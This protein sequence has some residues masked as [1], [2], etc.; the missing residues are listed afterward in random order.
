MTTDDEDPEC[1]A[2]DWVDTEIEI[3]L[4]SGCCEHV[5]DL[6][7]APGY[8][9]FITESPGSKRQQQFIVGNGARVPNEGQLLLNMESSTTAGVMKL[10]SCF[11]VAEVT[12]PLMSV[13]RVCDQGLECRFTETE[14][15]V[16]SKSGKTLVS[17]QRQG[18]LYISKMRLKPPEGFGGPP[19]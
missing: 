4:D 16:M 11:Q 5:M 8:S 19:R 3:C 7:D 6:G 2:M 15:R 12:R 14:A 17:F 10:Q 1:L 13:S 9:A 18:G